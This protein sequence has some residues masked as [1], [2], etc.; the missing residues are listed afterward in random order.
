VFLNANFFKVYQDL[1]TSDAKRE[2]ILQTRENVINALNK[3]NAAPND[4]Q[5]AQTV[6][7]WF[8]ESKAQIDNSASTFT[9]YGFAPITLHDAIKW[10]KTF[11]FSANA[12]DKNGNFRKNG[13]QQMSIWETGDWRRYRY[14]DL[15]VLLGWIIMALL[16]SVGAPFWQD[17]LESLFGVKNLLRKQ[18][19]TKNVEDDKGGQP[20][21]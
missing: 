13:Q 21:T 8:N 5:V 15:Q 18:S 3:N 9:G 20:R 7:Q 4:Q 10:L 2:L 16:L 12:T 11:N 19:D 1:S 14:H 6:D 17:A